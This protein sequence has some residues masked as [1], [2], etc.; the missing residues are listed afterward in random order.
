M[1]TGRSWTAL[2]RSAMIRSSRW[3]LRMVRHLQAASTARFRIPKVQ[4][5]LPRLAL[6]LWRSIAPAPG[7]WRQTPISRLL[8]VMH[9]VSC[10]T[11]SRCMSMV[12]HWAVRS[13]KILRGW[14]FASY[15][16]INC[17]GFNCICKRFPE[18]ILYSYLWGSFVCDFFVADGLLPPRSLSELSWSSADKTSCF[19]SEP[20]SSPERGWKLIPFVI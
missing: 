7:S 11:D 17:F 13:E 16:E 4:Q 20:T 6:L 19:F 14:K 18:M 10:L 9:R 3:T 2:S 15:H 12:R 8:M 5:S 1:Q